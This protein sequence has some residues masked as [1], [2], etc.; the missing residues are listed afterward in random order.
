MQC[1]FTKK[2][3]VKF[4]CMASDDIKV[5][6]KNNL[7]NN[8]NMHEAVKIKGM[9]NQKNKLLHMCFISLNTSM[10]LHAFFLSL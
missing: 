2:K 3:T 1:T 5:S 9:L 6:K 7:I 4:Y 8:V 10:I